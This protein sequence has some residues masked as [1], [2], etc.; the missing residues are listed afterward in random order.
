[1]S[2]KPS[3]KLIVVPNI[4]MYTHGLCFL[5]NINSSEFGRN[6]NKVKI[7]WPFIQWLRKLCSAYQGTH[8]SYFLLPQQAFVLSFLKYIDLKKNHCCLSVFTT[9]Y[10]TQHT[11]NIL[12]VRKATFH[13]ILFPMYFQ[14]IFSTQEFLVVNG[15]IK[16]MKTLL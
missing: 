16:C 5:L 3:V 13:C 10:S 8:L 9:L 12:L 6:E 14:C 2:S 1:M 15:C 11:A 7:F 4:G